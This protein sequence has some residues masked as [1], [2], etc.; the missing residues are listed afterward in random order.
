MA[1][2]HTVLYGCT[3]Y[4]DSFPRHHV[5]LGLG[6]RSMLTAV[7]VPSP[8]PPFMSELPG[9]QLWGKSISAMGELGGNGEGG[10]RGLGGAGGCGASQAMPGYTTGVE[11]ESVR[12]M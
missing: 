1:V 6:Q 3:A 4:C 7:S 5:C 10:G 9:K 2:L 11:Q 8:T 12:S